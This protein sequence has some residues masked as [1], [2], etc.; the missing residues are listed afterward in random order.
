MAVTLGGGR[1]AYRRQVPKLK[2]GER[3]PYAVRPAREADLPFIAR[4]YAHGAGRYPLVCLRDE[5][6]WRYELVGRSEKNIN[7]RALSVVEKA[8]GQPVGLVIHADWLWKDSL[9]IWTYELAPGV[10][11]LAVAPSAIRALWAL[12]EARAAEDPKQEMEALYF[13]LGPE[14]PLYD[15]YRDRLPHTR[16]PYAWY[17]RV[18]DL[19]G[20]LRHVAPVLERRLA[21]SVLVG[22]TGELKVSFYRDGLRLAF[23]EGRLAGAEPWQPTVEA[24]GDAAFPDLTF[25]QLL[26]GYRSLEELK[27]AFADCWTG[28]DEAQSLLEVLF[29][30]QPSNLWPVS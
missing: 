17:L 18:A 2:D 8:G 25:L 1:L 26:F 7:R 4:L 5:A 9:T 15:V 29:P 27:H 23:E 10:P 20:F 21:A 19:P 30:K 11:W 13:S 6:L 24:G 12:G 22:H 28:S 16:P 14:H 3:E